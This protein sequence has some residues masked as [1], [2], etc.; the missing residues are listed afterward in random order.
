MQCM[1]TNPVRKNQFYSPTYTTFCTP[2]FR[3]S[4]YSKSNHIEQKQ[5]NML[6]IQL[7]IRWGNCSTGFEKKTKASS[8]FTTRARW[9]NGLAHL[10]QWLCCLHGPGFE[11]HLRPVEFF[12]CNKVSPLNNRIPT[13]TS[14][15]C[16]PI[17]QPKAI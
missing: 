3:F 10:Q 15:P 11:S 13:L 17:I 8:H 12:P 1:Y 14:A 7:M 16:A 2:L 5:L 6:E 4:I 9:G